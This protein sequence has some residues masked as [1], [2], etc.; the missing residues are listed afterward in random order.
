MIEICTCFE[1]ICKRL[2]CILKDTYGKVLKNQMEYLAHCTKCE[3]KMK[4]YRN[5]DENMV[6]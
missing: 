5:I 2:H 6:K 3:E 4:F 1:K